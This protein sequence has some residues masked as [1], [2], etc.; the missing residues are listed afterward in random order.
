MRLRYFCDCKFSF[1]IY[2]L[3]S[4]MSEGTCDLR[5]Y[6]DISVI[7]RFMIS[8]RP[9]VAGDVLQS[10]STITAHSKSQTRRVMGLKF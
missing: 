3:C 6:A 5:S 4:G 9:G 2:L 1:L 8:N 7:R 10:Q